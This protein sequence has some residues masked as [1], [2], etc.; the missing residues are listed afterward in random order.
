MRVVIVRLMPSK[1]LRP[2]HIFFLIFAFI[3]VLVMAA[4]LMAPAGTL[5]GLD[6]QVGVIDNDGTWNELDIITGLI[7]RTGDYFCHQMEERSYLINGNQIPVCVRDLGL[8]LGFTTASF[9]SIWIDRRINWLLIFILVSPIV[10]DGGVQLLTDY[11][12]QN[13]IRLITG[14]LG[15]AGALL[16]MLKIMQNWMEELQEG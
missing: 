8:L 9:F 2:P 14:V 15:G 3:T 16:G 5:T 13:I 6:G 4:P 1:G 10:I 12:S 11:Q 7:Y